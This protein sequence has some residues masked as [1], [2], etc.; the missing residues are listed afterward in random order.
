MARILFAGAAGEVTGPGTCWR[1]TEK[2]AAGLRAVP[3]PP[4][5]RRSQKPEFCLRPGR[6]GR[7]VLFHA[8]LDH[9]GNIPHLVAG[10]FK[11]TIYATEATA[12]MSQLLL[13][14]SAHIQESDAAFYNKKHPDD[15]IKPPLHPGTGPGLPGTFSE[16]WSTARFLNPCPASKPDFTKPA[17]SWARP[18]FPCAGSKTA[19]SDPCFSAA[20]LAARTC[21]F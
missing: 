2:A 8:H 17:I 14:D 1:S 15:P 5:G 12:E 11:G 7:G 6:G 13:E 18:S 20:I 4:Q 3:G 21:R 19:R 10:G 16:A 9:S